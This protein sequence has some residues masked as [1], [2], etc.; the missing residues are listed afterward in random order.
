MLIPTRANVYFDWHIMTRSGDAHF[1]ATA[2]NAWTDA[3]NTW[4]IS[5]LAQPAH[6]TFVIAHEPTSDPG[7]GTTAIETAVSAASPSVTMHLYGH[8]HDYQHLSANAI[9]TGNA[10]APLVWRQDYGFCRIIDQREDDNIVVTSYSVGT[11]PPTVADTFVVTPDGM[12][13]Q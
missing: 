4:L 1:I 8:I 11:T 3:Q 10:G 6:Y 13:T 2:P 7:P 5:A 9:I 12:P